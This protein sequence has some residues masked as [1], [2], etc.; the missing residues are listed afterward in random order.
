MSISVLSWNVFKTLL[1]VYTFV[2][3]S[4]SSFFLQPYGGDF[5]IIS[6]K[7]LV[8]AQFLLLDHLGIKSVSSS[9]GL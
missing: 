5:P 4:I 8:D 6:V 9:T 3:F 7:D 2:Q 1:H